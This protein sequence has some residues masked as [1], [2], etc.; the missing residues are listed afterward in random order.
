MSCRAHADAGRD[1]N[2]D[3]L[4]VACAHHVLSRQL[5]DAHTMPRKP[6]DPGDAA[7][8]FAAALADAALTFD[9]QRARM[10][11]DGL[12]RTT[13]MLAGSA[14]ERVPEV[15][16]AMSAAIKQR[17]DL[18]DPLRHSGHRVLDLVRQATTLY[19]TPTDIPQTLEGAEHDITD[20]LHRPDASTR[21]DRRPP[22][23]HADPPAFVAHIA[24]DAANALMLRDPARALRHVRR[25]DATLRRHATTLSPLVELAAKAAL[26]HATR[27]ASGM[28]PTHPHRSHARL[29]ARGL[30][31][32]ARDAR[33]ARAM[34]PHP[35]RDL[36]RALGD[37]DAH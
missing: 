34:T 9:H 26:P 17:L 31:H 25:L 21:T 14:P 16:R 7:V 20:A 11:V 35:L 32:Y 8:T 13:R 37:P 24:R 2:A 36:R 3:A 22:S 33:A 1:A 29:L 18:I 4:A 10:Y 28:A 30:E 15:A 19:D 5:T 27:I 12:R 23:F 6:L